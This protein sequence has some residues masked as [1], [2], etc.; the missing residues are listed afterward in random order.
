MRIIRGKSVGGGDSEFKSEKTPDFT[1]QK[2]KGIAIRLCQ[3]AGSLGM[4]TQYDLYECDNLKIRT[5]S[6]SDL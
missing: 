2:N 4:S 3:K 5:R 6:I 1:A